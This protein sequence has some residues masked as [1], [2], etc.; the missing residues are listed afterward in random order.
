MA[1]FD[2]FVVDLPNYISTH[3]EIEEIVFDNYVKGEGRNLWKIFNFS[4][5]VLQRY[6]FRLNKLIVIYRE[7]RGNIVKLA[8]DPRVDREVDPLTTLTMVQRNS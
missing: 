2:R 5:V 8:V 7:F 4:N 1:R 6:C 3:F